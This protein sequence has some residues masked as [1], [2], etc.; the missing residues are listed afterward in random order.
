MSLATTLVL[1]GVVASL[2]HLLLVRLGAT[3]VVAL[4]VYAVPIVA[5]ISYCTQNSRSEIIS[6]AVL[7]YCSFTAVVVTA[8]GLVYLIG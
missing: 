5:Y 4:L 8:A 7:V 6:S 2:L 3:D 1:M